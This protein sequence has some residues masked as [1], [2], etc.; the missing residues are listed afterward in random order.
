MTRDVD[1][2]AENWYCHLDKGQ[3][4]FVA[5]VDDHARTV[6]IQNFDG[7]LEEYDLKDW[8]QLQIEPCEAPESWA[9][10]DDIDNVDDYGTGVTD[11]DPKDWDEPAEQFSP[12]YTRLK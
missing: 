12:K 8:Y 4:F 6:E 7:T 1:P 2:I 5:A 3:R 10:A 9:G 11:T